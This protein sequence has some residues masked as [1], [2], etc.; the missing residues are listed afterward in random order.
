VNRK[1]QELVRCQSELMAIDP[2]VKFYEF[3]Q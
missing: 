2:Q 3:D 1:Y